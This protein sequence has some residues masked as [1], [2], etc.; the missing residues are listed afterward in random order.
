LTFLRNAFRGQF[1]GRRNRPQPVEVLFERICRENAITQRLAKPRSPTTRGKIERFHKTLR[2]DFFDHVAPFESLT[3]AQAAVDG[4]VTSYNH[5]R[6]H[7]SLNMATPASLF[8]PNGPTRLD[9]GQ[10]TLPEVEP[11]PAAL[12]IDVIEPPTAP[13]TVGVAVEFEA[14]VPPSGELT[15]RSGRQSISL[16]Q[17][18]AGRTVTIWADLRSIH[19]VLDGHVVRTAASRLLP[20]DVRH[21]T[22]RGS[23]PAGPEPAKPALR[24]LNGTPVV[25]EGG[26]VEIDRSVTKDGVVTI[27]G[28]THLMGFAHASRKITLRLDGHLMHAILDN[29]L[30]GSWPCPISTDRLARLRG[31]RTPSTPLPPPPLSAGS[32]RAQRKVQCQRKDHGRQTTHQAR[33]PPR[34]QARHRGHR[35]HPSTNL[36]GDEEIAVRPRRDLTPIIRLHVIGKGV[37]PN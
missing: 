20:D 26:A 10:Q 27:A 22:M 13:T 35:G 5:Q 8:R 18:M 3:A 16:H 15:V 9:T 23:R 34:R 11:S 2:E 14:R 36:H 7:Q 6:P 19:V 1:T 24:R 17:A 25:P 37:T 21:L 28:T 31:A 4:W 32:V 30:I 12:A 29:V 33:P